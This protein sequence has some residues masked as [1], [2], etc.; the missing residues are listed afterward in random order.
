MSEEVSDAGLSVPRSMMWTFYINGST[1]LIFL[2]TILFAIPSVEEALAHPSGFPFLYVFDLA[3]PRSPAAINILTLLTVWCLMVGNVSFT[4][5]CARQAWSFARDR[6]FPCSS[7]I[8]RMNHRVHVPV[9]ATLLTLACTVLLSLINLGSNAAFNAI[10]SLQLSALMASYAIAITC[11]VLRKVR[12]PASLPPARWSLGAWGLPI[13]ICAMCYAIFACFWT[14]WPNSTP[15]TLESFNWAP[16]IFVAV[17]AVAMVTYV[18][19][20]RFVYDGP[21]ALVKRT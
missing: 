4:A 14:F 5:S 13:N 18:V 1:G 15:V 7:W 12:D 10:L 16:V 3:M 17:M 8:A 6:G 19:Q 20:G 2:V 11:I 21:V 9:N